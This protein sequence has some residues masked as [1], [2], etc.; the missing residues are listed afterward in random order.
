MTKPLALIAGSGI[1][2]MSAAWWLDKA[3]WQCIIIEKAPEIRDGGYLITIS[4][5][6]YQTIKKM[7]LLDR[8]TK[9]SQTFDCNVISDNNGKELCRIRYDDVHGGLETLAIRRG[10]LARALAEALPETVIIR[11]GRTINNII[12][13]G[14]T[15]RAV[16]DNGD[17]IDASI[18]IGADGFHSQIRRKFWTDSDCLESLGYSYA[19][20]DYGAESK[21]GSTCLSFNRPGHADFVYSCRDKQGIAMHIWSEERDEDRRRQDKFGLLREITMGTPAPVQEAVDNAERVAASPVIDRVA[22]VVLPIWSR[23]RVLLLGDAAHCLTLISGQGAGTALLSAE[24]LG[25]ELGKTTDISQAFANH[26]KKLRPVVER[27]QAYT[28]KMAAFYIPKSTISYFFRNLILWLMPYSWLISWH[29]SSIKQE[30]D[31]T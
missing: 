11:F 30:I 10:D 26:E 3:G 19:T 17:I 5:H 25:N 2:G 7:N 9:L 29:F 6:G 15:V 18:L 1:A 21:L 13:Q 28:R 22:Q 4:G 24:I 14:D 16:L 23:G 12:E 27:L 20:Y 31:L 8:L